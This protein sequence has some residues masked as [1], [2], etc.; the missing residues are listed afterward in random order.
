MEILKKAAEL[1]ERNI[2]FAM[3]TIIEASGSTPRGKGKML[4]LRDGCS[5]GT[6]GGGAVEAKVLAE[7]VMALEQGTSTV[8]DFSLGRAGSLKQADD[9]NLDMA[10]GGAMKIFVEVFSGRPR[11]IIVGGGHVGLQIARA[12]ALLGYRVAVVDNRP[13]Y[14]TA[15]RFSMASELYVDQDMGKAIAAVPVDQNS[16]VVVSTATHSIDELAI[17]HFLGRELRYFGLLGSR[18]KVGMM[19][20]R[21]RA[22]GI[23]E[24]VLARIKAPIGLDIGAETPEEIAVSVM[25]EIMATLNGRDAA[26][27]SG[28][29]RAGSA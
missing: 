14:V 23:P 6:I 15:E 17:R 4:V 27:L 8:L 21:L 13:D 16:C 19:F 26:P 3:A 18:H 11:L 1:A 7:A 24:Q 20:E 25:A 5:L 10:C 12:G 28:R 9:K 29:C 2:P 22:E